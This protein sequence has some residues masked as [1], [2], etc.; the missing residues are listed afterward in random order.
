MPLV[1]SNLS[2]ILA[3]YRGTGQ[4]FDRENVELGG[5]PLG[6]VEGRR[7]YV[8][9]PRRPRRFANRPNSDAHHW[10]RDRLCE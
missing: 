6:G 5:G 10:W 3:P 7:R 4:S 9:P 8:V 1:P 2:K